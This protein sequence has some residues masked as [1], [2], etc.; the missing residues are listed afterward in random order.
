MINLIVATDINGGIGKDN[1]L[2]CTLKDDMK[3]FKETTEG[4][5]VVM[6]RKTFESI[7]KPLPD[8]TN[9]VLTRSMTKTES[10]DRFLEDDVLYL[11]NIESILHN[12]LMYPSRQVFIV[13]GQQIYEQFLSYA[14]R[15][16]LTR[17]LHEF[18]F[19]TFFPKINIMEDWHIREQKYYE[20]NERNEHAFLISVLDRKIQ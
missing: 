12:N 15:I 10:L 4:H 16:Y 7:G 19:D 14:N 6:G 1:K 3:H 17:I 13:G 5:I 11:D 18:D 20:Q 9:I 2:L 8:R